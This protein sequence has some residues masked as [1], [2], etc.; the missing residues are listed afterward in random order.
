MLSLR[1]SPQTGV[2]AP[3]LAEGHGSKI[4]SAKSA[5]IAAALCAS[6]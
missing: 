2:A 6:Q 1:T 5:G 3:S 4:R